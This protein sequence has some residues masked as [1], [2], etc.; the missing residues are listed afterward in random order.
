M[1]CARTQILILSA[2]LAIGL[3]GCG[4][5]EPVEPEPTP[6]PEPT[7]EPQYNRGYYLDMDLDSQG[8]VWLAY[9]DRD[10]TSLMAARGT[11]SPVEFEHFQVEGQGEVI[12]GLLTGNFDGG[13]YATIAVDSSDRPHVAHWDREDDRL[14]YAVR[15]G[16]AWDTTNAA[17][18]GG[19]FASLDLVGGTDPIISYYDGGELAVAWK[20]GDSW[21]DEVVDAGEPGPEEIPADVGKYSDLMVASDGT[22]WIAYYD[23]ANG[24]L[25]VASGGP[26]SWTVQ[27]WLAE[28]DVGQWPTLS[29]HGGDV[30]VAFLDVENKDL[31]FGRWTGAALETEIVD[32]GDFVGADSAVAWIGETAAIMYHDGV[33]NNAKLAVDDGA[34]WV[35]ST[36]MADGAVGFYNSLLGS[37]SGQL[38]WACFDHTTTDIVFQRFSL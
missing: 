21:D 2:V 22:V 20:T 29:E 30:Y 35:V 27:V 32:D 14:R 38:T 1:L 23:Q 15:A 25:K 37:E 31:V 8:R 28:G 24:D 12:G 5:N 9:Q 7:P 34:G 33:D 6:T 10:T 16:G 13:N 19:Q 17:T 36:H 11:G 4:C 18:S 3:A 26:G